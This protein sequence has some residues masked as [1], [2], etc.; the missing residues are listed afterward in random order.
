M[1]IGAVMALAVPI[2]AII[3]I[4]YL[5]YLYGDSV[6]NLDWP[7]HNLNDENDTRLLKLNLRANDQ[8][9]VNEADRE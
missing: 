5:R 7:G 2:F 3:L 9:P 1:P 8:R 6:F 4:L